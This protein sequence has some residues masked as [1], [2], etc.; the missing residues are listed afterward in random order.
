M[1]VW[2]AV[3]NRF[4]DPTVWVESIVQQLSVYDRSLHKKELGILKILS[5]WSCH[6]VYIEYL[7]TVG[8][9]IE[10]DDEPGT[11]PGPMKEF[12]ELSRIL[13]ELKPL[14][15]KSLSDMVTGK[16]KTKDTPVRKRNNAPALEDTP[17]KP[18]GRWNNVGVLNFFK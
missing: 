17:I 13:F 12:F 2:A 7:F 18:G 4:T 5:D 1:C 10:Y 8:S 14:N 3:L 16:N 15:K 6:A 9:G 11:G